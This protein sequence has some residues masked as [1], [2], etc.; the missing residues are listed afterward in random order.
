MDR[1]LLY[2]HEIIPFFTTKSGNETLPYQVILLPSDEGVSAGL[3]Q[4]LY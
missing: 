4:Q 1:Q 3:Q 2:V